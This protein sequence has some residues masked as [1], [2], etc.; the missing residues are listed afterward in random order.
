MNHPNCFHIALQGFKA[1]LRRSSFL[2]QETAICLGLPTFIKFFARIISVRKTIAEVQ[3]LVFNVQ[4]TDLRV[5]EA[6]IALQMYANKLE[7]SLELGAS[8]DSCLYAEL[9]QTQ[10]TCINGLSLVE[11]QNAWIPSIDKFEKVWKYR[12]LD[13]FTETNL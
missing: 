4:F 6:S 3:A 10:L 5:L 2:K 11:P 8:G 1:M 7:T 12:K 13:V 9:S